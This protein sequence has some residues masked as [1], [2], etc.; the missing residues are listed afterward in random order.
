MA[1]FLETEESL[2]TVHKGNI[3]ASSLIAAGLLRRENFVELL[4]RKGLV[5]SEIWVLYKDHCNF[6]LD[7]MIE[8]LLED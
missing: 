1:A 7:L 2:A 5:G 8:K 6:N 4:R 3:G